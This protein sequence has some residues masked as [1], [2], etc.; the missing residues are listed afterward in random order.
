MAATRTQ[1]PQ[2]NLFDI[3]ELMPGAQCSATPAAR[4]MFEQRCQE[5]HA[6]STWVPTPK[7]GK[8][9][10]DL[11]VDELVAMFPSLDPALVQAIVLDSSSA[12][13]AMETFLALTA[14]ESEPAAPPPAA[15]N[16]GIESTDAF[17]S[18]TDADGWQVASQHMFDRTNDDLGSAWCER[19]KAAASQPAPQPVWAPASRMLPARKCSTKQAGVVA[20]EIVQ[21]ETDYD[22]R[23]RTGKQRMQNRAR[24]S[25]R[26]AAASGVDMVFAAGN[27]VGRPFGED[28]TGSDE[29][30]E[31]E[32]VMMNA[33]LDAA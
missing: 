23:Q 5:I 24:F 22:M 7:H 32:G 18:L 15:K 33:A 1:R 8:T 6:D 12:Q 3:P 25:R 20:P 21:G 10:S 28:A 19:A 30:V 9:T 14:A 11:T 31:V 29:E 13:Q 26:P 17:P 4:A 2:V 16:I 27:E